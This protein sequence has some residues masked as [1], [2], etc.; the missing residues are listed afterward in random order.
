MNK[1]ELPTGITMAYEESGSQDREPVLLLAPLGRDHSFVAAEAGRFSG[2]FRCI[3][4]DC[5]G[6]GASD[7]PDSEYAIQQFAADAAAL[8]DVLGIERAHLAGKSMGSTVAMELA[9]THPDRVLSLSLYT[10]WARTD[11]S[12]REAFLMLRALVLQAPPHEVE[13]AISWFIFTPE[14]LARTWPEIERLIDDTIVNPGYPSRT[15]YAGH[16]D[17]SIGHDVLD[18]LGAVDAPTLVVAGESD[19]LVPASHAKQVHDGIAGSR[20]HLFEGS[21]SSHALGLE[22]QE[23]FLDLAM[24]F[25]QEVSGARERLALGRPNGPRVKD[26]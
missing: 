14:Y 2:D 12:L 20:F 17:A 15:S 6:T 9:A 26:S 5:R 16:F 18:R 8:L 24:E 11:V 21:G 22:R 7:R 4:P 3:A 10:P 25:L 23:E 19:R 13:R 1:A